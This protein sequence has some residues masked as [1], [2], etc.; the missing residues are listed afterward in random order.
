MIMIKIIIK[1]IVI[2]ITFERMIWYLCLV[3]F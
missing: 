1:I 2:N 3:M